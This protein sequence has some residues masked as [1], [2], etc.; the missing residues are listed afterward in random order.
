MNIV[1]FLRAHS[2]CNPGRPNIERKKNT[3]PDILVVSLH[4]LDLYGVF[5]R[6]A[7][8]AT[9]LLSEIFF[10]LVKVE[11]ELRSISFAL[12][13]RGDWRCNMYEKQ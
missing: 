3:R 7:L 2:L 9:P 10:S 13:S 8:Q 11:C 5:Q 1:R 6:S 4:A 12:K